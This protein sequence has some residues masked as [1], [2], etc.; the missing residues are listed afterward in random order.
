MEV[1]L[2]LGETHELSALRWSDTPFVIHVEIKWI[3]VL[4]RGLPSLIPQSFLDTQNDRTAD[5]IWQHQGP[6][7]GAGA[8]QRGDPDN[9]SH[10]YMNRRANHLRGPPSTASSSRLPALRITRCLRR[11]AIPAAGASRCSAGLQLSL[12]LLSLS[13]GLNCALRPD[14]EQILHCIIILK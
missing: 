10:A 7:R 5:T 14:K 3:S 11:N 8:G 12:S 2:F 4:D 9:G 1:P 13:L 6:W